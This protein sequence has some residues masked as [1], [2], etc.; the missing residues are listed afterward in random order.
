MLDGPGRAG[1]PDQ[2]KI[3]AVLQSLKKTD[4]QP[5]QVW[6][7]PWKDIDGESLYTLVSRKP[8]VVSRLLSGR[9][10]FGFF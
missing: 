8:G 5:F 7:A 6:E 2:D 4:G 3:R 1:I 10:G 9:I